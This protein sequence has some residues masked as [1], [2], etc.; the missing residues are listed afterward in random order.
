MKKDSFFQNKFFRVNE[1]VNKTIYYI[2]NNFKLEKKLER[3]YKK[4]SFKKG[5]NIQ[6]F[7]D[8]L[9]KLN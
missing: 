9:L 7:I 5:H 1:V 6:D 2:N 3:F 8:Y 4:F